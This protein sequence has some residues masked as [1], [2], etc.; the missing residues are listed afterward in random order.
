MEQD[1]NKL[2]NGINR[3]KDNFFANDWFGFENVFNNVDSRRIVAQEL[4]TKMLPYN[5]DYITTTDPYSGEEKSQYVITVA[6]AGYTKEEIKVSVKGSSLVVAFEKTNEIEDPNVKCQSL[7]RGITMSSFKMAWA[8]KGLTAKS[9]E[10]CKLT[11]GLLTIKIK[12]GTCS[13]EQII[14]ISE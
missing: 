1:K 12:V 8:V 7:N 6:C 3:F 9:I 10:D 14:D 2:L 4:T 5:W 13:N 11:N